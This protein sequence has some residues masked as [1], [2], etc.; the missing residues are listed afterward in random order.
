[1][2]LKQFQTALREGDSPR[3]LRDHRD[4]GARRKRGQ[5]PAVLKLLPLLFSA[6]VKYPTSAARH[7]AWSAFF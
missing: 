1:M 6:R 4:G 5:S 2:Q 3:L 7:W